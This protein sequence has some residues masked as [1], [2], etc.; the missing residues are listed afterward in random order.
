MVSQQNHSRWARLQTY[1]SLQTSYVNFATLEYQGRLLP[2]RS[3]LKGYLVLPEPLQN[4]SV[5]Y[6]LGC[7]LLDVGASP[8]LRSFRYASCAA[9]RQTYLHPEAEQRYAHTS[10]HFR[11]VKFVALKF[12][13]KRHQR[14]GFQ[15][16][17]FPTQASVSLTASLFTTLRSRHGLDQ[18][19]AVKHARRRPEYGLDR[20]CRSQV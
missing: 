4:Q 10:C 12:A 1:C 16:G 9:R 13:L 5:R 7:F 15:V 20:Q 8:S 14:I 18:R 17:L 2:W 19:C 6:R 3:H 11:R